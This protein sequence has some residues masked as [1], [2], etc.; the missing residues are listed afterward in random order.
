MS[1]I[2]SPYPIM[3]IAPAIRS[4]RGELLR[5]SIVAEARVPGITN[6]TNNVA[7]AVQAATGPGSGAPTGA[8]MRAA[9]GLE[10]SP[11]PLVVPASII[12]PLKGRVKSA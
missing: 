5:Q 9:K 11:I 6:S 12:S 1:G 8:T 2:G 7:M 3:R 4:H 10:N